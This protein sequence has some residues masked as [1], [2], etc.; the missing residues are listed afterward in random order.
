[1][2]TSEL[3]KANPR[4]AIAG[5]THSFEKL[6]DR[7]CTKWSE[8]ARFTEGESLRFLRLQLDH[9]GH[10]FGQ[11]NGR[12]DL[13]GLLNAQHQWFREVMQ[14]Y[15]TQSLRY[16]TVFRALVDPTCNHLEN[17]AAV[18]RDAV[19][20]NT[21]DGDEGQ[22]EAAEEIQETAESGV[23]NFAEVSHAAMDDIRQAMEKTQDA[24]E[25][26]ATNLADDDGEAEEEI[27]EEI[28]EEAKTRIDG[29]RKRR[30]KRSH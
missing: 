18:A 1:M 25:N 10:A 15:V 4:E 13:P 12:R 19:N 28:P 3:A 24:N 6:L 5:L 8:M 9:A 11:I 21:V 2:P 16:A 20:G 7:N 30:N 26:S 27:P 23:A 14:D 29:S 22:K 17:G